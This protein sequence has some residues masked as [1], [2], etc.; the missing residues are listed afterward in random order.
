MTFG[1]RRQSHYTRGTSSAGTFLGALR[2]GPSNKH[3][4]TTPFTSLLWAAVQAP[5]VHQRTRLPPRPEEAGTA[6]API[7]QPALGGELARQGGAALRSTC[8]VGAA[9]YQEG[10]K[11]IFS[12]F[13]IKKTF[14]FPYL[15]VT[16][17]TAKQCL[18]L[19]SVSTQ[20]TKYNLSRAFHFFKLF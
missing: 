12:Y 3:L 18:E 20:S 17:T 9:K 8:D 1:S 15:L 10:D 5:S 7:L 6:S 2:S 4:T 11:Q 19:L 13:F 14:L 16:V